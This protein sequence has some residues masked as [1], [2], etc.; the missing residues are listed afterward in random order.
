MNQLEATFNKLIL[1]VGDP[2]LWPLVKR[3][4]GKVADVGPG[5][6]E[7]SLSAQNLQSP[8]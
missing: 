1:I 3:L 5:R 6:F 2:L 8:A 4:T 7:M